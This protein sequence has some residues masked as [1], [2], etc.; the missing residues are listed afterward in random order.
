M[1]ETSLVKAQVTLTTILFLFFKE[2]TLK[3]VWE[4]WLPEAT[5]EPLPP[6]CIHLTVS[7]S[8]LQEAGRP[9][10]LMLAE[11]APDLTFLINPQ[12][13]HSCRFWEMEIWESSGRITREN[14][15]S[16]YMGWQQGK[17][18]TQN[19]RRCWVNGTLPT[20]SKAAREWAGWGTEES[21]RGEIE[22]CGSKWQVMGDPHIGEHK[23]GCG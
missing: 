17:M 13:W 8:C 20:K 11:A 18:R 4:P 6:L 3:A 14:H 19:L 7:H 15:Y 22:W 12:Q 1:Q 23:E 5:Q 9:Q 2:Q 10:P 16:L 21:L